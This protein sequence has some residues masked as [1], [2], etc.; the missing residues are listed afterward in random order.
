MFFGNYPHTVDEK[1]RVAIPTR[2]REELSRL[3]DELL[4]VTKFKERD[5]PCLDVLPESRWLKRVE[6]IAERRRADRRFAAFERWYVG[7]AQ[8]VGLDAQNRLLIPP[9]LRDYAGIG[10]E[11]TLAGRGDRFT[12]WSRELFHHVDREDELEA[13]QDPSLLDEL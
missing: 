5:R 7:A 4:F 8:D 2:F 12:I 11:V 10:R 3:R 13:F 9:T 1:G 6:R